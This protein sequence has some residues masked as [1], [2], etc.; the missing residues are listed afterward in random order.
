MVFYLH[1]GR[2]TGV[3]LP[4][5]VCMSSPWVGLGMSLTYHWPWTG[6]FSLIDCSL[7]DED[8]SWPAEGLWTFIARLDCTTVMTWTYVDSWERQFQSIYIYYQSIDGVWFCVSA[9]VRPRYSD[10]LALGWT[11]LTW[12]SAHPLP[13]CIT[14]LFRWEC[15]PVSS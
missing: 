11:K 14:L 12:H 1:I 2:P 4:L 8:F 7:S 6:P 5:L 13:G 15:L 9:P 10:L 3:V